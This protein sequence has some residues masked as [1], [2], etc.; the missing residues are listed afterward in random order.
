MYIVYI[1][2]NLLPWSSFSSVRVWLTSNRCQAPKP[3]FTQHTELRHLSK[4]CGIVMGPTAHGGSLLVDASHIPQNDQS[5]LCLCVTGSRGPVGSDKIPRPFDQGDLATWE[6]RDRASATGQR[7]SS[8]HQTR[9]F[10][11]DCL[12][13]LV[14]RGM[15]PRPGQGTQKRKP[16]KASC[17]NLPRLLPRP[18]LPR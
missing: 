2:Q 1:V 11:R 4:H 6:R 15:H 10:T 14:K 7:G 13:M 3:W 12:Q 8:L 16:R 9:E 5:S 18:A 17:R